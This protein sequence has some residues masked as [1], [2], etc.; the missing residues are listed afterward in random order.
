MHKAGVIAQVGRCLRL[1]GTREIIGR[2]ADQPI[3]RRDLLLRERGSAAHHREAQHQIKTALG[4]II[5]PAIRRILQEKRHA[6]AR[7]RLGEGDHGVRQMRGA[8]GLWRQHLQR[9]NR[10]EPCVHHGPF[11]VLD[12]AEHALAEF[13][14]SGALI[15]ETE[16]TRGAIQKPHAETSFQLAHM[17]RYQRARQ[18]ELA[19]GDRKRAG[20]HDTHEALHGAE[21][22]HASP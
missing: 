9:P 22:I 6:Q 12:I 5:C 14:I 10:L 21:T 3:E 4:E 8:E 1:T 2:G 20:A 17:A 15:G 7:L 11:A 19:G 13:E 16:R 18:A